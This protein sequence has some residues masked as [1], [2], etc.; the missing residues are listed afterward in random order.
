[1]V[2]NIFC[3]NYYGDDHLLPEGIYVEVLNKRLNN[4]IFQLE[5]R[6]FSV[7][8]EPLDLEEASE[9]LSLYISNITRTALKNSKRGSK[10]K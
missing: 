9:K 2:K 6:D 1:M 7:E 4:L 8:L 5:D 10:Y 3:G